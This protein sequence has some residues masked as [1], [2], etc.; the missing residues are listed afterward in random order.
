[1]Y[2]Y[3][4][5]NIDECG[6]DGGSIVVDRRGR[7]IVGIGQQS[8]GSEWLGECSLCVWNRAMKYCQSI[9]LQGVTRSTGTQEIASTKH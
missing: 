3:G 1:M 6:E 8:V 5:S 4:V 9:V 7:L 2:Y